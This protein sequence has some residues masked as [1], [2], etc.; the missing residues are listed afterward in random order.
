VSSGSY[1]GRGLAH[2]V[3]GSARVL[4]FGVS[5]VAPA[6]SVVGG[7]VILVSYAGFASPLVVVVAFVA[8]LCCASS[9]AE[10]ARRLPSAGSLY[11]YNSR[12]LGQIGGFLTGWMMI[13]AYALYAPAG[14]ALTSAF[15]SM[16]LATLLHVTIAPWVLFLVI[17]AAVVLVACLGIA[18]SSS[19]DL[20]L[21]AG[22]VAV[23]AALA[24]TVLVKTGPAHYSAAVFS[25][26]S[27]PHGQL[28]DMTNAMIY[29]ISA[30]AGFEAAAALGE[31]ARHSRRSI[32]AATIGVV[33]VTGVF[34][35]LVVLAETFG[36]GRHGII[37]LT[38][39]PSP[40]GYLT[41]RYWSPSVLWTIELVVVL[42]G[43][44]FV[45]AV[46]NA[47]I[48]I[49]FAMG[50]EH[51]LPGSLARLSGRGTPVIATGC[52]AVLA[53][54][55][56]LPLTYADGGPHTF[57]YLAGAAALSILLIYLAVNIAA[58][59]AFRTEFRDRFRL[60]RHLLLPAAA[61]VLFL[62]PLW[63][64][65]HPRAYTLVNLLPFVAFGW[66]CLGIIA[67]GVLHAKR[68]ASL[69]AVG[70]VFTPAEEQPAEAHRNNPA[71]RGPLA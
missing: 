45:I 71:W 28:S 23:I 67:A 15:A 58:I 19:V 65:L 22:E 24:I 37:G 31:E 55:L 36:T 56:G 17:V 40:L 11:T 26:A 46:F 2:G 49:L 59:R 54:V 16:L 63:G 50:R 13:A 52:V 38:R 27:S 48:R 57:G 8:S 32:P 39:Q 41:S 33:I 68:P 18:V 4:A 44:S 64:I 5:T 10:F 12:G 21:A 66:L 14:V 69:D 35:L 43:L 34:Y 29:G 7:L 9:I 1:E 3:V 53:L 62:F 25:P 30:F 6:G 60:W 42:T 47:A 70:R 20:L 51:V 61:V